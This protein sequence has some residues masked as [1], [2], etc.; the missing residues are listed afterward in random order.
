MQ[1]V[2]RMHEVIPNTATGLAALPFAVA[3]LMLWLISW[4][5]GLP[6]CLFQQP[7]VPVAGGKCGEA[8]CRLISFF[9]APRHLG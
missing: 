7:W 8:L 5:G 6:S 4:G 3:P 2:E 1:A 9:R